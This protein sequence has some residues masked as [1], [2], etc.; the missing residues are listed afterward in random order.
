M[1]V[2]DGGKFYFGINSSAL[3]TLLTSG[4]FD[5]PYSGIGIHTTM[6]RNPSQ[7]VLGVTG[8]LDVS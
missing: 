3:L 7:E 5:C 2:S 6:T 1:C 4:A 8:V